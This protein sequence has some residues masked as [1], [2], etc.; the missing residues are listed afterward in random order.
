MPQLLV[1][2]DDY[3]LRN[4]YPNPFNQLTTIEYKLPETGKVLLSVFNLVGEQIA[5]LVNEEQASGT[6]KVDFDGSG[7]AS[8]GYMYKIEVVGESR[9]FIKTRMMVVNR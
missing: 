4:N 3:A 7:L 6:Y 2:L 8:G 5:V 1:S 9:N